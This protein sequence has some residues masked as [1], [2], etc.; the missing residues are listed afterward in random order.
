M[1]SYHEVLV[2]EKYDSILSVWHGEQIARREFE[3]SKE[4]SMVISGTLYDEERNVLDI[5][6]RYRGINGR[7]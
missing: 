4:N 3:K 7:N 6:N 1:N 5:F 2:F